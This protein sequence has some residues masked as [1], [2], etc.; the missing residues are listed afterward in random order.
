MSLPSSPGRAR[1]CCFMLSLP[2]SVLSFLCCSFCLFSVHQGRERPCSLCRL[3][4]SPQVHQDERDHVA[5]RLVCP[6]QFYPFCLTPVSKGRERP[7]CSMLTLPLYVLP[8]LSLPQHSPR[9]R[10]TV[11]HSAPFPVSPQV[12]QDERDRSTALGQTCRSSVR[13][14]CLDFQHH[15]QHL[16]R[17]ASRTRSSRLMHTA[18]ARKKKAPPHPSP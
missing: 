5:S 15:L 18:A 2:L 11:A 16:A 6:F 4:V 1:P 14:L 17:L 7:C 12:H 3:S 10:E 9:A 13:S 8:F